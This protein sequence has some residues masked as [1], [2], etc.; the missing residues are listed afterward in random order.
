MD[1]D[2]ECCFEAEKKVAKLFKQVAEGLKVIHAKN[3]IHSDIKP[4]IIC[5]PFLNLFS[6]YRT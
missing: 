4:G 3:Y 1:E 2:E 6:W 5:N